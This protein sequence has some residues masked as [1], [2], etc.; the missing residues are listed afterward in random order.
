MRTWTVSSGV[1]CNISLPT[2]RTARVAIYSSQTALIPDMPGCLALFFHG[3]VQKMISWKAPLLILPHFYPKII[4]GIRVLLLLK[5]T[6]AWNPHDKITSEIKIFQLC[7]YWNNQ[8]LF[9]IRDLLYF[10][11]KM[12]WSLLRAAI[13]FPWDN[14]DIMVFLFN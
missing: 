13:L 6:L 10:T 7:R 11:R 12:F 4:T 3:R 2:P 9:L 5:T 14:V 1:L 8:K